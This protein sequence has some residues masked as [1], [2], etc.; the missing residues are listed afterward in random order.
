MTTIGW[1]VL[2]LGWVLLII[3]FSTEDEKTQTILSGI[4]NYCFGFSG[5]MFVASIITNS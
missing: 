5:A 1:S 4:A 3:G 2:V